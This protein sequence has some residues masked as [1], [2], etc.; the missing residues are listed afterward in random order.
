MHRRPRVHGMQEGA[1]GVETGTATEA[2]MV[3]GGEEAEAAVAVMIAEV[4]EVVVQEVSSP[5]R[6]EGANWT[7]SSRMKVGTGEVEEET[8]TVATQ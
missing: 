7:K 1:A 8:T 4:E 5:P 3:A 2:A 6:N